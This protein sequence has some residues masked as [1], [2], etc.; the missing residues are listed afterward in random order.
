M[1]L[2]QLSIRLHG[3]VLAA[4]VVA[5]LVTSAT[6]VPARGD[7]DGPDYYKVVGVAADD[8]LNIRAEPS[9]SARIIGTIPPGADNVRSHGCK[10]GLTFAEWEK[11]TP[12]ERAA[13][14]RN[15]WCQISYRG[16]KGWVAGRFLGEGSGAP[17][18]G[19]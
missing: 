9:A 18:D 13:G 2:E 6:V 11:A 8:V 5:T 12:A 17:H 19:R 4:F 7:A 16:M 3:V 14:R 15:R 10:G 1:D